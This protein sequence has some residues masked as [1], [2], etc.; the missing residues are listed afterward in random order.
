[1]MSNIPI[2]LSKVKKGNIDKEVLRVGINAEV[3]KISIQKY[4]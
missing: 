3:K 4:F 2:D 1:M